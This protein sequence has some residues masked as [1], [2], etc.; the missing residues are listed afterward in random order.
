MKA[1]PSC[2]KCSTLL[3]PDFINSGE[4][5]ECP[6]CS[7]PVRVE[8]FPAY[9]RELAKGSAGE[10]LVI[11]T[12][13]SCFYHPQKKAS[14]VCA[15]CGRFLCALCDLELEGAHYCSSCLETAKEKGKIA[16]IEN[17]RHLYDDIALL[18]SLGG[19][20]IFYFSP[21]TAP[22][23]IYLAVKHW[24]KPTS[25]VRRQSKWRFITAIVL[26]SLQLLGWLALILYFV[27]R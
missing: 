26:S 20:L 27:F 15:S 2:S 23:S 13:A 18:L 8:L 24:K 6:I 22:I 1:A 19:I 21:V 11:D 7:S 4:F 3:P 14:V 10:A 5:V 17:R 12:E 16:T 9:F 25:I